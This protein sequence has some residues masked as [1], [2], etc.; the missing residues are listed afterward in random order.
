MRGKEV[1]KTRALVVYV[2]P[3]LGMGVRFA[4]HVA[5]SQL[6]ILDSWLID[7]ARNA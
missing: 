1:F 3:G 2:S 7:A 5:E 6:R 4:E